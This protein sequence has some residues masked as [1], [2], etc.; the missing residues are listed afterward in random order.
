M[1]LTK[2]EVDEWLEI[3]RSN[4]ENRENDFMKVFNCNEDWPVCLYDFT[5][6]NKSNQYQVMKCQKSL[7]KYI[8]EDYITMDES[9]RF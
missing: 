8:V 5:Y 1:N 9:K 4:L 7:N 3:M 6:K 2:K